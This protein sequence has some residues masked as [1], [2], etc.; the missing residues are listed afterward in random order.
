MFKAF[1]FTGSGVYDRAMKNGV[2]GDRQINRKTDKQ[3][4]RQIDLYIGIK[5]KE[6]EFT[7]TLV[8]TVYDLVERVR[9]GEREKDAT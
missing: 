2:R 7:E 3:K 8:F 6:R 5:E 1:H 4:D 9:D